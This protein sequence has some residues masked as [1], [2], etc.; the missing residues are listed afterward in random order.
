MTFAAISINS[1]LGDKTKNIKLAI[2]LL[3][4][5]GALR[6]IKQSS[7]YL[8]KPLL[9]KN[10]KDDN[11]LS[12]VITGDT[13]ILPEELFE[14]TS[15]IENQFS[16]DNGIKAVDIDILL[17]GNQVIESES[18]IIP[19]PRMTERDFVITPLAE[20]DPSLIYFGNNRYYGMRVKEIDYFLEERYII[21]SF[22][23]EEA[24]AS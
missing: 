24:K 18:L 21:K 20:I 5:S 17:Y 2:L 19:H 15:S 7:I 10:I 3:N 6:N 16:K 23:L 8:T 14:I 13:N 12:M 4:N 11:S 22:D 1:H 9:T